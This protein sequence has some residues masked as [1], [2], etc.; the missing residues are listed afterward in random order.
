MSN[1]KIVRYNLDPIDK[2]NADINLIWG[3]KGNGKSYQVKHKKG[4]IKFLEAGTRF[5]LLRRW[6]E[7]IST[8]KVEQYFADVDVPKITNN[9]YNC[10]T[11]YRK[12]LF[13]SNYNVETGKTTRGEK[14]GYVMALSTEQNYSGCSY[15][16]VE[17]IIYEEFMSRNEYIANEPSKLMFLY[18]TIDRK[19]HKVRLWLVGNTV[20]RVCP[21]IQ[22]WDLHKLMSEQKQGTIITKMISTGDFDKDTGK[23]I[24]IKLAV[25]YC[26]STG[27]SSYV[28]GKA[29][30]MINKGSWLTDQQPHLPK[31][32]K[33]YNSI[34]KV[35]FLYK[36]F[37]FIGEF[38]QDKET[39][40]V[41]WF[42]KPYSKQIDD[43]TIVI[44]DIIKVSR[45]WIRDIYNARFPNVK[46]NELLQTFTEDKIFYASDLCGT[47]FKQVIDFTIRK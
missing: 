17:D 14:I 21:Y 46:I 16:D 7:E 23:E 8:D 15:L 25:E 40:E 3:E 27:T 39:K 41:C 43:K 20:S 18:S 12:Q 34:F 30:D 31:S 35:V 19:R 33:E 1:T 9:K 10:I 11:C 4:V 29:K 28:I 22:D 42:V 47:D 26:K 37:K 38:L 2:E 45:Y 44:S 6:K 36:A 24:F 5:V 13:Y 32:Y